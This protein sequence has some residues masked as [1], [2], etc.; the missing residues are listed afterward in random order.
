MN[1]QI[2][3]GDATGYYSFFPAELIQNVKAPEIIFTG[4]RLADRIVKPGDGG[5]VNVRLSQQPDIRLQ[6]DQDV[7]SIDYVAIDYANPEENQL[8]YFLENYDNNWHQSS[9]EQ[10]AYYFN[11]PPGKYSFRVKAVNSYG[12]WAE[13]K[14]DLYIKPPWWK[15][16]WAYLIYGLL[17]IAGI[18]HEIQNPLNF[19][20]NISEVSHELLDE[21]KQEL[22]VGSRQG[23]SLTIS[24][25]I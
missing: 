7:F 5:P 8:I 10:R 6:Y 19:V 9:S 16:W 15:T 13:K 21:M 4:F 1:G 12:V 14:I 22:A 25:K 3:F 2:Y 17:F 20:N 18:A 24:G 23:K 11:I